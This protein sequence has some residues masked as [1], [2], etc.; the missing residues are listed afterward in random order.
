MSRDDFINRDQMYRVPDS[1]RYD[2][3]RDKASQMVRKQSID[4]TKQG[5][6]QLGAIVRSTFD[7]RPINAVDTRHSGLG[8]GSY[9]YG[10]GSP[11]ITYTVPDGYVFVARK[12]SILQPS[13]VDVFGI[14]TPAALQVVAEI[15][16]DGVIQET[17]NQVFV[18]GANEIDVYAIAGPLSVVKVQLVGTTGGAVPA[19]YYAELYGNL[20]LRSGRPIN[21]EIGNVGMEP[22][23]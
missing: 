5:A 4:T 9:G 21:Y 14:P 12:V 22:H 10:S 11:A 7:A 15:T 19:S 3:S 16:V 23:V 18:E 8:T 17:L 6:P 2:P 13:V 20:L 1:S